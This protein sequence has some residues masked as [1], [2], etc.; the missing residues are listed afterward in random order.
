MEREAS[1]ELLNATHNFPCAFFLKVI[2][3]VSDD[4]IDR[5]LSAVKDDDDLADRQIP[6]TTRST[7]NGKHISITMEPT[8]HSAEQALAI[9]DRIKMVEGVVM[10]M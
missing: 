2:G 3:T 4:F 8:L 1:I 10:T 6:L 5:V 7:P 9:Y